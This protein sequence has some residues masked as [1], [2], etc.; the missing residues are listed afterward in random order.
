MEDSFASEKTVYKRL[1]LINKNIV[2]QTPGDLTAQRCKEMFNILTNVEEDIY[3]PLRD[4]KFYNYLNKKCYKVLSENQIDLNEVVSSELAEAIKKKLNKQLINEDEIRN[5]L[6]ATLSEFFTIPDLGKISISN[7]TIQQMIGKKGINFNQ[8]ILKDI[9]KNNITKSEIKIKNDI[10]LIDTDTEVK[11]G[12][13]ITTSSYSLANSTQILE[14]KNSIYEQFLTNLESALLEYTTNT[15][16]PPL[17]QYLKTNERFFLQKM[18]KEFSNIL[19]EQNKSVTKIKGNLG[20]IICQMV[21]QSIFSSYTHTVKNFGNLMTSTGQAAVDVAVLD[22]IGVSLFGMQV[23]NFPSIEDSR[24]FLLYSTQ[25]NISNFK[26]DRYLTKDD[27][28]TIFNSIDDTTNKIDLDTIKQICLNNLDNFIRYNQQ[29]YDTEQD[30]KLK[31]LGTKN[32][33]YIIN[34]RI[35]PASR[36]FYEI[37]VDY[38]KQKEKAL[39]R[40]KDFFIK[41]FYITQT[42]YSESKDYYSNLNKNLI[43]SLV[44]KKNKDNYLTFSGLKIEQK[45][46]NDKIIK[47]GKTGN[48]VQ[49]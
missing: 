2:I 43:N 37:L 34:F 11:D 23:K 10:N 9:L 35:I 46:L 13:I 20:E 36:I 16:S 44:Y 29:Y 15:K 8:T 7:K 22:A 45:N 21:F 25:S 47:S 30:L 6:L 27:K 24:M 48:L 39:K 49:I 17:I 41:S 32:N 42:N 38:K 28:I 18:D 4:R 12:K 5:N 31:S 33:F 1:N 26:N 40:Q 3:K 14:E 19:L